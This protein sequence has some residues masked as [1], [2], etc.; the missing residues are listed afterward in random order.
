MI[1]TNCKLNWK[2]T[3][4][5]SFT[6]RGFIHGVE[7]RG[8]SPTVWRLEAA[9]FLIT[10]TPLNQNKHLVLHVH[11]P[12]LKTAEFL[13]LPLS[14]SLFPSPS[15]P[16]HFLSPSSM[17]VTQK[18]HTH[19]LR[20]ACG[21]TP[22]RPTHQGHAQLVVHDSLE[23]RQAHLLLAPVAV[24]TVTAQVRGHGE[25]RTQQAVEPAEGMGM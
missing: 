17:H 25:G 23:G 5:A 16:S 18:R 13:S 22:S 6:A 2:Q 11:T 14:H 24:G 10:L 3:E 19:T 15:P 21:H 8:F 20:L 1:I 12:A 4:E 9:V 7:A